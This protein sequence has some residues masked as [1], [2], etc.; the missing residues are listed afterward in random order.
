MTPLSGRPRRSAGA[1][2][3][4]LALIL[5]LPASSLGSHGHPNPATSFITVL[6]AGGFTVP[7]I[8]SGETF[9]DV[10]FQGIPDGIGAVP[11]DGWVDLYVTHEESTVPFG[12][13]ADLQASSVSRVRVDTTEQEVIE[14]EVALGP[15]QGFVRFCSAFMAG[16]EHGF[17]NYTFFVNEEADETI[18]AV[19]PGAVYGPD[20]FL[21][22]N[23]QAGYSV[24]LDTV[25]GAF[26]VISRAGRHNHENTV[27]IPGGWNN[28][29]ILSS[30]DTFNA[31]S[32]QLYLYTAHDAA[33]MQNDKGQL[34]AFQVTATDEGPL[35]D[36]YD[37]FNNAND[38]LEIT[39]SEAAP[40]S[41]RFIHVPT[42]VARG[43]TNEA[44]QAALENWSNANNVFQFVRVEDMAYDPD[45]PRVIY[46]ADTGASRLAESEATGRLIRLGAGGILSNGRIFKM[47][48]NESDPRIV[49]EFSVLTDSVPVPPGG[50]AA[51]GVAF[52]NPDNLAVGETSLMMQEDASAANDVWQY[53]LPAG[54][55]VKV[56]SV[57]GTGSSAESSGIISLEDIPGFGAGWW[58]LDVQGHQNIAA[59]TEPG[60]TWVGPPS[61]AT[62]PY[63]KRLEEGQ[64]LLMYIPGS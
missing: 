64:L 1:I 58:A 42:D 27:V 59:F 5:T 38:F 18:H 21:A 37:P 30:D 9:D 20:P 16:P 39:N 62:G 33:Q 8:N 53:P 51:L 10:R 44:P 32:S 22:P 7:L 54:P 43:V 13:F 24:W 17:T 40:W 45:N 63:S 46:F 11:G 36:P 4:A 47:V 23:R 6:A 57:T 19:P 14:L 15:E 49:D 41:G 56:A 34:W 25:T 26:D 60:F 35:A 50:N 28:L 55:W 61:T 52:L 31:P 2:L 29:A 12:G 48:L 3:A